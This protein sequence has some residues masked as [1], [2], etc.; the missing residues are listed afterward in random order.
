MTLRSRKT[1][2]Y[3][4]A[5]A[6]LVAITWADYANGYELGLF[7]FYFVPIALAAWYGNRAAGVGFAIAAG[8]GWY[9]SDLLSHHPYSNA[10]LIYWETFMR[11]VVF[12]ATALTL[13]RIQSD[14]R[15]RE[16]LLDVISHDLRAP[17]GAIVGQAEIVRRV[18]PG[19]F[20]A[21]RAE[22]ILRSA[23]RMNMMIEDLVDA[24]RSESHQLRLSLRP[25]DVGAYLS[26]LLERCAPVLDGPR[27]RLALDRAESVVV[28]ADPGRL[29]RIVLNLLQNALKYSPPDS[30]V[31]L[32]AHEAGGRVSIR[33]ADHGPGI[34][35]DELPHVFDRFYRGKR[36]T[37]G[38]LGLGLYSVRLLVEAH[39]GTVRA[40]P[41]A[42]GGTTF[43]V[44][45][46]ADHGAATTPLD[47][48]A[49]ATS[50]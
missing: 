11:T 31:E 43:L 48:R 39:H 16:E 36:S 14:L 32:G 12:L 26:E 2:L 15:R 5:P 23:S 42:R 20:A 7:V 29:D 30:V 35:P 44:T 28:R 1:L 46:P 22:A 38:G 18:E 49:P 19:A 8:V 24:A 25:V 4:G 9:L 10:L 17:L 50:A 21:Q 47:E 13:S 34:P 6:L 40:E 33:V 37:A 3:V 41:G 45:L 27:V